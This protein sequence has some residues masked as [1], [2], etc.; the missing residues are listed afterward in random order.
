M[1]KKGKTHL[2]KKGVHK[3]LDSIIQCELAL[4]VRKKIV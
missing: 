2:I 1:H 4:I 3:L